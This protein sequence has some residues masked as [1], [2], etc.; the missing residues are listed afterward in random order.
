MASQVPPGP[1]PQPPS[2]PS[3]ARPP[4]Q[5][6]G[7]LSK[8]QVKKIGLALEELTKMEGWRYLEQA[9]SQAVQKLALN[10]LKDYQ[11]PREWYAGAVEGLET[12]LGYVWGLIGEARDILT[13]EA[14]VDKKVLV[15]V[16]RPGQG[17]PAE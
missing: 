15:G 2:N 7:E 6:A 13:Q 12:F 11:T 8:D 9:H 14:R 17:S 3:K 16:F 4:I 10:S 1:P 5:F